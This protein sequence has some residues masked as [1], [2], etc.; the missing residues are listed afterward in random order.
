MKK[1]VRSLVRSEKIDFLYLQETKLESIDSP[2][3]SKLWVDSE[4][5]WDFLP[6]LGKSGGLLSIWRKDKFHKAYVK[7]G[8]GHIGIIGHCSDSRELCHLINVYLPCNNK[9]KRQVWL[10]LE[11][12]KSGSSG[13][14]WCFTGDFNA[15]TSSDER[16]GCESH[17]RA[18]EM[19]EFKCFIN[20][21]NLLDLPLCGRRFTWIKGDDLLGLKE[22]PERDF[23]TFVKQNWAEINVSGWRMYA[24]KEKLKKLKSILRTWNKEKFGI[25]ETNID[26]VPRD[27]HDLDLKGEAMNLTDDEV[28]RRSNLWAA[29][30]S[31]HN[32]LF[33][34]SRSKWLKEDDT[35][36]K[37][38]HGLVNSRKRNNTILG[39][40]INGDWIEDVTG[41]RHVRHKNGILDKNKTLAQPRS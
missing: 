30:S 8:K 10:A 24:L 40:D 7:S 19:R 22:M 4:F 11:Q 36:S 16:K 25:I 21:M 18:K 12:W 23:A 35:N 5:D 32:L 3:C 13:K 34:K 20:N 39:L 37:Y 29:R 2:L 6:S 31:K 28:L 9:E 17:G 15:A 14:M 1:A 38:F 41:V 33:Q 27:I 26:Y